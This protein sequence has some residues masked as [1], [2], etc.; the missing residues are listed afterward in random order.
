MLDFQNRPQ[1]LFA[2]GA[3]EKAP[4]AS[5]VV[6]GDFLSGSGGGADLDACLPPTES[7]VWRGRGECDIKAF[8]WMRYSRRL[9]VV[10]TDGDYIPLSMLQTLHDQRSK[11]WRCLRLPARYL[12][13]ACIP[14]QRQKPCRMQRCVAQSSTKREE[15]AVLKNTR[16]HDFVQVSKLMACI[17]R[18]LPSRAQQSS[19]SAR[20]WR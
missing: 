19:S 13:F 14:C 12:S 17:E 15:S 1:V 8:F 10:S 18:L 3:R 2:G 9:L 6:G 11:R 20:W 5:G 16:K 4:A 7:A